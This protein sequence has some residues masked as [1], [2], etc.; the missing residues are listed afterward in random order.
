MKAAKRVAVVA[1]F[2]CAAAVTARAQTFD[3][4]QARARYTVTVW[5][6]KEG[7]PSSYVRAIAQDANG[8]LWLATYSG[9]VRFDLLKLVASSP[10]FRASPDAVMP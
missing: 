1:L 2:V 3:I 8:Y 10:A 9:L 7:M 4:N 5:T 6:E